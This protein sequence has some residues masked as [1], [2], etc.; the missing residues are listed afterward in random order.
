M[1]TIRDI[2]EQG[3]QRLR[4]AGQ[5][6]ARRDA[7]VLLEYVLD[8]DRVTL[9]AYPER[10]VAPEQQTRFLALIARREQGEPVAY[11][12]GHKEFYGLDFLVDRRVLI[13]RPETEL[14]VEAAL[15]T[16][17]AR[18]AA[19]QLPIV[20]D[21]GT[22][23]GIIPIT[24]AVQEPRLPLLYACDISTEALAVAQENCLRQHVE[25]RV[26]LLQGDLLAP[27]PEP[28]DVLTANLPYVGTEEITQLTPDVH[29]YEPHQALFSGPQG[30]DLLQRFCYE[31]RQSGKIKP[32]ALL[33]LEIGYQQKES[34]IHLLRDIWPQA[35]VS[36]QKD[37]SGWDRLLQVS[38]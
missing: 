6:S 5:E 27:L 9:Y 23:S 7:Q 34:I 29:A 28:V 15:E 22:G 32:G 31:A 14:L 21:I 8:V 38:V 25:Q 18:L 1:T 33:L 37:Y 13:P 17:R 2:W 12:L 35:R 24:L 19:G 36:S 26:R 10:E 30:L 3:A 4:Q 20:A 16:I 11:L